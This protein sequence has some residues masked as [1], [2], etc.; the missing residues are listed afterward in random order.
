AG[1]DA[2]QFHAAGDEHVYRFL[3]V[4]RLPVEVDH[5]GQA[6][7]LEALDEH[8]R[9]AD[10]ERS[11]V[12]HAGGDAVRRQAL[13]LEAHDAGR[14]RLRGI[15]DGGEPPDEGSSQERAELLR[16]V[17]DEDGAERSEQ[18]ADHW[19]AS[20]SATSTS[21]GATSVSSSPFLARLTVPR[22]SLMMS[23]SASLTSARPR[24][25]RWRVPC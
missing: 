15:T 10:R 24:P 18:A 20:F 16:P 7:R 2:E 12:R 5:G 8:T 21:A 22:S 17:V 4:A 11:R 6:L 14:L 25:A 19:Y 1:S 23:T 9:T 3:E 13:H